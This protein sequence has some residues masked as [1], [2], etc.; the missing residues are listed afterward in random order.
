MIPDGEGAVVIAPD[1]FKDCM[2]AD[3]VAIAIERGVRAACPGLRTVMLPLADG[4]EGTAAVL[5]HALG[6]SA[7][8]CRSCDPA[9]RP[10]DCTYYIT[11]DR[12][13]AV[14]DVATAG[15]IRFVRDGAADALSADS[16]GTGVL[17]RD[18]IA[19]GCRRIILGLGGSGTTDCG[20]GLLEALG[21]SFYDASGKGAHC[22]TDVARAD[23]SGAARMLEGVEVILVCDVDAPLY[24][25]G[26]AACVFAPQKGAS[27]AEVGQLDAG[28][29]RMA[30]IL[31]ID[32]DVPGV[33]AAGGI[34]AGLLSACAGVKLRP[35]AGSVLDA[36]GFD[37]I[38]QGASLV[39][40][41]EGH[42]DRQTLMGKLP[43]TVMRRASGHGV[44]VVAVAGRVDDRH[45]L[46]AAGFSDVVCIND[47][48]V[49]TMEAAEAG[50]RIS[51]AVA[52]KLRGWC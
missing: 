16:Y 41:G 15:G 23:L 45:S 50:M 18:A 40:T 46:L 39:V 29:R 5:A 21:A 14:A 7:V 13:T 3:E 27:P 20:K 51:R 42:I 10:V 6:A 25:P 43:Y 48:H 12:S 37:A 44:P 1:S 47:G 49:P 32:A 22:M 31:G 52:Q 8:G 17:L 33:G 28:L 36:T 30:G 24:G 34:A 4:G 38:V 2:A 9:R 35:G 11:T 26:G 19:R